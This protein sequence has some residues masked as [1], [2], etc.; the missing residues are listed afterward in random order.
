M[1]YFNEI[2]GTDGKVR[3]HYDDVYDHWSSLPLKKRRMLHVRSRE[4]FS[5]DYFQDPFPR[6]L[7][8]S[9]FESLSRGVEQRARAI[10]AFLTDYMI[11]GRVWN[12]IMSAHV[13][14]SAIL[15]HHAENVLRKMSPDQLAFPYGP[16]IIRDRDGVWRVVEDSAGI[17][18]GLG[19]L[20][21]GRKILYQLVPKFRSILG[22]QSE[23]TNDPLEFFGHLSHHFKQ[24]AAEK[25]GIP[26]LYLHPLKKEPDGETRRLAKAFSKFG[27]PWTTTSNRI[28]Q[29]E[30][31]KGKNGGVF[32]KGRGSRE[33]VGALLF[34]SQP[35]QFDKAWFAVELMRLID[36][37][38]SISWD[39]LVRHIGFGR[40]K[41]SFVRSLLG[42]SVWTNFSPCTQFINDKFFGLFVDK[43]IRRFLNQDPLLI[44]LSAKPVA[45]WSR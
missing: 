44:S 38:I 45:Y 42:G 34:R 24:K 8:G 12:S 25:G 22:G 33:R 9:E 5:G 13:L 29:L 2:F 20:V 19:D 3:P 4:L 1:A 16:D 17:L 41:V 6:I 39:H 10:H 30:I 27:I 23:A 32:L 43:M 15:R 31:K 7:T 18:G 14:H 28:R 11:K 26:L 36:P 40:G 35:E 21:Q 37:K